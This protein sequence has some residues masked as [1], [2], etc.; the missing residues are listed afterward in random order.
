[1]TIADTDQEV[2]NEKKKIKRTILIYVS[3]F[4]LS[5]ILLF[6]YILVLLAIIYWD[7]EFST[8]MELALEDLSSFSIRMLSPIAGPILLFLSVWKLYKAVRSWAKLE[9]KEY[10]DEE[11]I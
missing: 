9:E 1:M 6:W 4:F 7:W 11:I 2:I 8:L 3:L 10:C 5:L